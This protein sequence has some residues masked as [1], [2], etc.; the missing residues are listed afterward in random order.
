LVQPSIY[1]SW[2]INGSPQYTANVGDY[3]HYEIFFKNIG[4]NTL[5][6]LFLKASLG[7][8][9]DLDTVKSD[10]GQF[11]KDIRTI[12][13]DQTTL[14]QLQIL[15]PLE[16]GKVDFWVKSK[17]NIPSE[18]RNPVASVQVDLSKVSEEIVTKVNSKLIISQKGYY[19]QGLF[20]NIGP[21]PPQVGTTTTYNISWQAK[22]LYNDL[23]NTKVRA[24]IPSQ[25]KLTGEFIPKEAKLSFDP[26]S[27]EIVWEIGDLFAG[28]S[29]SE[30]QFQIAFTPSLD[31]RGQTPDIISGARLTGEDSWTGKTLEV[32]SPA[33][34]T[35]LPDDPTVSGQGVIQ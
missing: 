12:I 30:I 17:N 14:P 5:E 23:K 2:Q 31:Q 35:T 25:V 11:Q 4:D 32:S 29:G 1:I 24:T 8:V 19:S 15:S 16:E 22:S 18:V 34:N 10:S 3:L 6:N 9:L 33:V 20:E 7:G 26:N 27:R 21:Y 28:D 13:W